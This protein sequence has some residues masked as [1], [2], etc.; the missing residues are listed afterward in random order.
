MKAVHQRLIMLVF[1]LTACATQ[2]EI[3]S[4]SNQVTIKNIQGKH[5]YDQNCLPCHG[6]DGV[7]AFA[8]ISDLTQ[9]EA[10][11]AG[12]ASD[13]VLFK[14][15]EPIKQGVKSSSGGVSMPPKGGNPN[16]TDQD[17]REVLKYMREKFNHR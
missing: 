10:F 17:I 16:L 9:A 1:I 12:M 6:S 14:Y 5:M 13:E 4:T 3:G 15:L 2:T 11:N 8:G 7:G